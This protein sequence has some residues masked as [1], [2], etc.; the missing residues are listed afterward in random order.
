MLGAP[1]GGCTFTGAP[2]PN[3][4]AVKMRMR[5]WLALLGSI[6]IA[7]AVSCKKKEKKEEAAAENKPVETEPPPAATPPPAEPTAPPAPSL[8]DIGLPQAKA[9]MEGVVT[10]GQPTDEMLQKAKDMGVKTDVNLRATSEAKDYATE[11]KKA[12]ELGMK[13]ISI[14]IDAKT[15]KG[16]NEDSA[17]KL[18]KIIDTEQKPMIV[19]CA[20]GERVGALLTLKAF[21][22]DGKSPEEALQVG[23]DAGLTS[24]ALEKVVTTQ[25]AK[26]AGKAGKASKKSGGEKGGEEGGGEKGADE[27]GKDPG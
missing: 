26:K 23:H 21:Y 7:M 12:E 14:P 5:T 22:V 3:Q 25:I 20:S 16:L 11:K 15:G 18:A 24:P 27:G 19:H 8:T 1:R 2:A 4:E 17:K 10:G 6:A 13:Y 9:P